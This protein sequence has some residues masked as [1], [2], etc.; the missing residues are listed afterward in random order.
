[1]SVNGLLG[2]KVGMTSVFDAAGSMLG[3][4]VIEVSPNQI[5]V[6]RTKERD[7]YEAV[8]LGFGSRRASRVAKPQA[9]AF[10]KSGITAPPAIVRE[11]PIAPGA[12][13]KVG[14]VLKV[15]DI[16]QVGGLVD[17]SGTSVGK[18]FQGVHKRWHHNLGP[19]THGSK[20]VREHK[21]TGSNTFPSR[22]WPG[23]QMAGHMG[24]RNRT[25]R[26]LRVVAID[27]ERNLLLVNGPIPGCETGVVCVRHAVAKNAKNPAAK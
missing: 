22:R 24:A 13:P 3:V 23:T 19:Q 15:A 10:E 18:G 11:F 4:S 17:V 7:G 26:N 20:N 14:D 2:K 5:V 1:M 27:A 21:S 25:V 12:D 8:A 6:R 16:F 9:K